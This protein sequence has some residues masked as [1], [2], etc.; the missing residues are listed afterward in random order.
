MAPAYRDAAGIYLSDIYVWRMTI[1]EQD[2]IGDLTLIHIW[3]LFSYSDFNPQNASLL[4]IHKD[5]A[6]RG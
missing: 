2:N 3:P 6:L 1:A 4:S 5:A